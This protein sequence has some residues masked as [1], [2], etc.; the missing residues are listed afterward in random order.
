M[1]STFPTILALD[2]DGVICDGL[3]EYFQTAWRTYCQIW[4]PINTTPDSD[5]ALT[6]YKLRP[7]IET[8]WEMPLLI[9]ALLLGISQQKILLDWPSIAQQLLLENNLTALDVGTKLDTLRDEWIAK[10]LHEWLSLHRFYPGVRERLQELVDSD[11]QPIIVTTKEGR[12]VQE[13]LQ[14]AGV[15]MPEGSII[16]K[17]YKKPKHQVLRELLA[18]SEEDCVIW[19]VEDRLKTLLSVKQQSDLTGVR[20]FLADWGYNTLAERESV[21]QYPPV[22]LLSLSGFAQD[23]AVWPQNKC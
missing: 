9:Q 3:V 5:L 7:V 8:G 21:A 23:F 16:G 22:Q 15:E 14:I 11:V 4:Q 6:F 19:F 18:K 2:F 10:D 12:F 20:L 1:I 17:E 13:I